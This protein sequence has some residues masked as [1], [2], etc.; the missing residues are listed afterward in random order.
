MAPDEAPAKIRLRRAAFRLARSSTAGGLIRFGFAHLGPLVSA[1]VLT[2][3][4]RGERC[5]VY[6]HPVPSYGSWHQI[7]VPLV[8][9]PDVLAFAHPRHARLRTDLFALIEQLTDTDTSVLVNAGPRQDVG[10]LHFHLSDDPMRNLP[11][12]GVSWSDWE[13]AVCGLS[14]TPDLDDR[15]AAGFSLLRRSGSTDIELV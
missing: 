8:A 11:G 1:T 10:Q 12:S 9:V 2:T 4:A 7:A 15:Y 6:R 13:S 14:A 3:V 5:A